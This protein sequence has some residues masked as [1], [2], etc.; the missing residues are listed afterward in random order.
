MRV[1]PGIWYNGYDGLKFGAVVSGDYLRS[2]HVFEAGLLLSSGLGQAYLDSTV[3]INKFNRI[4][5]WVDYKTSTHRFIKKSNL[6]VQL[7]S[8]DGLDAGTL[9]FEKKNNNDK[10]RLY[11]HLKA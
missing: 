9:G 7:K 4:S 8:L 1:R 6:Y 5:F 11:T 10:T 3:S 2:K